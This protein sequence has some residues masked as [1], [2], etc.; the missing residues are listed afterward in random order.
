MT[1][2]HSQFIPGD[3]LGTVTGW[4]FGAV[5]EASDRQSAK[6]RAQVLAL[7]QSRAAEVH[8]AAV[9]QGHGQGYAL[10]YAD[11]FAQG[12]A[13][14]TLEGQRQLTEYIGAQ[15]VD[16][17][18]NFEQIFA[19]AQSQVAEQE[20]A[21]AL[22]VLELACA[23]ARKVLRHELATNPNALQ[24]VIREAMGLLA[25][26]SKAAVVRMHPLDV[27]VLA[28]TLR[29][30]FPGLQLNVLPDSAITRGGCVVEAA[31]TVIDGTV[32]KRWQRAVASLGLAHP[33][34]SD[35]ATE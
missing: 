2:A 9:A 5:D 11:G 8:E 21:M 29:Q 34:E 6:I 12:Q 1:R 26:D 19:S 28:G 3:Q 31:G 33:W 17:A 30:E 35:D 10:G 27:D 23:L 18:K 24:P 20:Q 7:E 14:A 25:V 16:I 13:Q 4:N 32:E 22:G 15:G